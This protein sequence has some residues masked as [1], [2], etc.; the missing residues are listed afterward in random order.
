MG[1]QQ[2]EFSDLLD[3][4]YT[5]CWVSLTDVEEEKQDLIQHYTLINMLM[6]GKFSKNRN[7]S[8]AIK[9]YCDLMQDFF[10]ETDFEH[11][12]Y[13]RMIAYFEQFEQLTDAKDS[14]VL[15]EFAKILDEIDA[16]VDQ[17]FFEEQYLYEH[18]IEIIESGILT[19]KNYYFR[20]L[21]QKTLE[22]EKQV[23]LGK[24][25]KVKQDV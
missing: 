9:Y 8:K 19:D 15:G 3:E 5:T 17:R 21:S 6:C 14:K 2:R 4:V 18:Y 13:E 12:I 16:K 23:I 11:E 24:I 20:G 10:E 7:L 1:E 25:P 22:E